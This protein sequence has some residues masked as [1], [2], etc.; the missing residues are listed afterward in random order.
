MDAG[1]RGVEHLIKLLQGHL[2][3]DTSG[4]IPSVNAL[5]PIV[6][7]L[8]LREDEALSDET[9][10]SLLY[11]LFGAWIQQRFSGSTQTVMSQDVAAVKS[12]DPIR[13]LFANLG[14]LGHRLAVTE[15]MLAGRGSTSPF[16]FLSYLCAR[17]RTATD[18]WFSVPVSAL[19]DGSYKVEY[20]HIHPRATLRDDYSKSEINDLANLAFISAKANRKISNRSPADYLTE[21]SDAD[22]RNHFIPTGERLRTASAYPAFRSSGGA[23]SP[24]R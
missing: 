20:H 18:W 11:W 12:A 17:G 22:L 4:L 9:R 8:G 24:R 7:F 21:L 14:L 13:N 19:H 10:D 2:L 5:V 3:A 1:E 6:A 23:C 15:A 16:F